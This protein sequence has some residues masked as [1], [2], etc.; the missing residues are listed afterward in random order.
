MFGAWINKGPCSATCG[1]GNQQQIRTCTDGTVH[2]CSGTEKQRVIACS[3]AGTQLPV[4][5]TGNIFATHLSLLY[6]S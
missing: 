2:K 6:K 3:S 4:C 1:P 5:R